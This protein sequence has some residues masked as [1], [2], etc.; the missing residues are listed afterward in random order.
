MIRMPRP[1]A[2]RRSRI[3]AVAVV[4]TVFIAGGASASAYWSTTATVGSS[5]AP[6]ALSLTVAN[7]STLATE[8][9]FTG[10][11]GSSPT[12]SKEITITNTGAAPLTYTLAISNTSPGL[13]GNTKLW[14]WKQTGCTTPSGTTGTLAAPPALPAGATSA[15]A[16]VAVT[17]CAATQ[18]LTSVATSQGQSNTATFTVTGAVGTNWTA[19]NPGTASAQA[20]QSVFRESPMGAITCTNNLIAGVS[21]LTLS[22]AA[23]PGANGYTIT[24]NGSPT[25]IATTTALSINL[26]KSLGLATVHG[27]TQITVTPT[28]SIYNTT[29]A[30]TVQAIV[31]QLLS[32]VCP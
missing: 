26:N 16:G 29:N 32:I 24:G 1:R 22:W 15:A 18:L 23:V 3:V 20:T 28:D 30:G 11:A 10:V 6:A 4:A 25:D 9:K 12:I 27:A 19:T 14:I 17:F 31:Q 8:W 7:A 5:V 21:G 13:A 2:P